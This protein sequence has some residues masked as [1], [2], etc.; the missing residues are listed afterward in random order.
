M[1]AYS[2]S[3]ESTKQNPSYTEA[4]ELLQVGD[5]EAALA[6][7]EGEIST[8]ISLLS[9]LI[10]SSSSS[11]SSN[12]KD[13]YSSNVDL[14]E[15]LAPLYYLYGTT[16]LYSVEESQN[17][18]ESVMMNTSTTSTNNHE[19]D[20]DNNDGDNQDEIGGAVSTNEEIT[21]DLQIAWENLETA[22]S[23]IVR[24]LESSALPQEASNKQFETR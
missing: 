15:A 3:Y 14:H 18:E 16:L 9:S 5:F 19:N 13:L 22:R 17:P 12:T 4:K 7:I 10:T 24:L 1:N 2:L 21:S 6:T 23:I 20:D 11:S 8:T